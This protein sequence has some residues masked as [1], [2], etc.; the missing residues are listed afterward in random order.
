MLF[1]ISLVCVSYEKYLCFLPFTSHSILMLLRFI[2]GLD[3]RLADHYLEPFLICIG[4]WFYF[5]CRSSSNEEFNC[6]IAHF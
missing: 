5:Y 4:N 3:C 1:F 6:V 2:A